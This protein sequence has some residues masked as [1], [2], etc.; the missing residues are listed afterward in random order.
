[1]LLPAAAAASI[2]KQLLE[3]RGRLTVALDLDETLLCTYRLEHCHGRHGDALQLV[4][5]NRPGAACTGSPSSSS[6]GGGGLSS[7]SW[8][9]LLRKSSSTGGSSS[10]G[11]PGSSLG[12]YSI[13]SHADAGLPGELGAA[14]RASAWM[15]YTPPP[16]PAHAHARASSSSPGG[17]PPQQ[18]Q[19]PGPHS[20]AVFMRPGCREFLCQLACF[21]E[22]VLFTAAAPEYGAPLAE[23]LDP[24]GRVFT[25]RLYADA[26]TSHAGRRGVKDLQVSWVLVGACVGGVLSEGA[27]LGAAGGVVG[28]HTR[29]LYWSTA[30]QP[31]PCLLAEGRCSLFVACL[32]RTN[33]SVT[34]STTLTTRCCCF[35]YVLLA[36][37]AHAGAGAGRAACRAG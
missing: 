37:R 31:L 19:T 25:G 4:P 23:L 3:H 10:A 11:S 34:H 9:S 2:P 28:A 8:S 14:A 30:R 36:H 15:H 26:C 32:A 17:G 12:H 6:G 13:S 35:L 27:W 24:S 21:A 1:M 18:L 7:S 33:A 22:L 16:R 20:L 5:A 29:P